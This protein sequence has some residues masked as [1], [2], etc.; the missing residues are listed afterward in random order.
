MKVSIR[1]PNGLKITRVNIY[2]RAKINGVISTK[3]ILKSVRSLKMDN[4]SLGC[5]IMTKKQSIIKEYSR[6]EI[7]RSFLH[8]VKT[9][10]I[11]NV[12]LL[13]FL[14]AIWSLKIRF[15]S[16]LHKLTPRPLSILS[17]DIIRINNQ[18]LGVFWII[19]N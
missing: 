8:Q 14:S 4:Q 10:S 7:S 15:C 18:K 1:K 17:L 13:I 19:N 12:I 3:L 6:Q 16:N 2:S 11:Q 5:P 9:L